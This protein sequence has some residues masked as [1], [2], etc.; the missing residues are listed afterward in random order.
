VGRTWLTWHSPH[1]LV[2]MV[3]GPRSHASSCAVAHPSHL[4]SPCRVALDAGDWSFRRAVELRLGFRGSANPA[5]SYTTKDAITPRL[6]STDDVDPLGTAASRKTMVCSV[7]APNNGRRYR[8]GIS[9]PE[10]A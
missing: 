8:L 5:V 6:D 4:V 7:S 9:L 1:F 3:D 2:H 10:A